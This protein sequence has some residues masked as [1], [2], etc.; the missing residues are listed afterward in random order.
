MYSGMTSGTS[1]AFGAFGKH[2]NGLKFGTT[3]KSQYGKVNIG[4]GNPKTNGNT[5]ISIQNNAGK[6]FFRLDADAQNML[7]MHYGF[8]KSSMKIHRTAI[9]NTAIGIMS[10]VRGYEK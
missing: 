2:L 7:H 5:L 1:M 4:Y 3:S 10:G 9:I 6:T 8:T